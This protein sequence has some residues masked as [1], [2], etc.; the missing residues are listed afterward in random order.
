M[1]TKNVG[2]GSGPLISLSGNDKYL[3][4]RYKQ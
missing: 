2:I 4:T 3:N 1:E